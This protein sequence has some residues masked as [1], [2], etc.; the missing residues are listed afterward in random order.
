MSEDS[1][2]GRF[3]KSTSLYLTCIEKLQKSANT[4]YSHIDTFVSIVN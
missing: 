3:S 1:P 2:E 4:G